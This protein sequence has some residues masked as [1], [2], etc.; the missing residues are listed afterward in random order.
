MEKVYVVTSGDYSDYCIDAIFSTPEKAQEYMEVV[1]DNNYN[2][3]QE[4]EVD[5]PIDA[6]DFEKYS[7]KGLLSFGYKS[8]FVDMLKNGDGADAY[9]KH[10]SG[11]YC[12]IEQDHLHATVWAKNEEHAIKIVNEKRIQMIA[13]GEWK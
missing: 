2:D 7:W 3:I 11:T 6:D 12:K 4:Y 5:I 10:V 9:Q 13:N 1:T 8:F